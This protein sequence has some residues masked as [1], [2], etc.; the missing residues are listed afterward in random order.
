MSGPD[1]TKKWTEL[2]G[3][4][5]VLSTYFKSIDIRNFII[6]KNDCLRAF[7]ESTRMCDEFN[8]ILTQK[9]SSVQEK[10]VGF[11][12]MGIDSLSGVL[13]L[14]S[15][16]LAA[17]KTECSTAQNDDDIIFFLVNVDKKWP[18]IE[19]TVNDINSMVLSGETTASL[20]HSQTENLALDKQKLI[21]LLNALD[22]AVSALAQSQTLPGQ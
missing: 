14:I 1:V 10:F 5:S 3:R 2:H 18:N 19:K 8:A 9:W 16:E 4:L 7:E 21:K 17:L 15:A 13:H 6:M 20:S 12:R 11:R 22:R